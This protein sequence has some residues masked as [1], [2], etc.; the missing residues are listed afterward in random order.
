MLRITTELVPHG[1]EAEKFVLS[2]I[3]IANVGRAD[4]GGYHY[5]YE[6]GADDTKRKGGVVHNRADGYLKLLQLVLE[7]INKERK[8]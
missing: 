7:D 8:E 3:D 2:T 5:L 1:N 4:N 6:L